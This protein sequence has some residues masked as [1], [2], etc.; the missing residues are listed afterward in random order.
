[1][2]R[3]AWQLPLAALLSIVSFAAT[4]WQAQLIALLYVA[5]VTPELARVD[6]TEH[7]LPN[8]LVLP[9]YAVTLLGIGIAWVGSGHSPAIA[10]VSGAAYFLF[11]LVMNVAGGMGMGDVKLSGVLGIGLGAL[12]LTQAMAGIL[13]AFV[14]GGIAGVYAMSRSRVGRRPRLA[15][16]PFLLLGFW[17]AV[18]IGPMLAGVAMRA[19]VSP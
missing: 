8:R 13:L 12:G 7:R 10:L 3:L 14:L 18:G 6:I 16:G 4:G 11:L 19:D 5:I 15:F 1:M 17:L 9:G 2:P